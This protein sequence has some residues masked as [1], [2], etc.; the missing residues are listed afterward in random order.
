MLYIQREFFGPLAYERP[1]HRN[2]T[3]LRVIHGVGFLSPASKSDP[4]QIECQHI[5]R[6]CPH[7]RPDCEH[8][9][10]L[11]ERLALLAQPRVLSP[12]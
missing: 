7:V 4:T 2:S 5:Q 11:K 12:K 10:Q 1:V 6:S 3:Q 9:P 8:C